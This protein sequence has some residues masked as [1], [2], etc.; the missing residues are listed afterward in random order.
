MAIIRRIEAVRQTTAE[1]QFVFFP[2][3]LLSIAS[4]SMSMKSRSLS[5]KVYPSQSKVLPITVTSPLRRA[6]WPCLFR[7][8]HVYTPLSAAFCTG[9]ITSRPSGCTFCRM[10]SGSSRPPRS[11]CISSMG[12]PATGHF[13]CSSSP[14]TAVTLGMRRMYGDP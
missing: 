6:L 4:R 11:Q 12:Y 2:S 7:A 5:R 14:A 1:R 9:L 8:Q 10:S 3:P 13:K